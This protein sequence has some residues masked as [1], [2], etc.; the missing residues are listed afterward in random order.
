MGMECF[1]FQFKSGSITGCVRIT[2]GP[3]GT[4]WASRILGINLGL[5]INPMEGTENSGPENRW[6]KIG[7][8]EVW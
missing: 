1:F 5:N 2:V 4:C 3:V 6:T 8:E 7:Q